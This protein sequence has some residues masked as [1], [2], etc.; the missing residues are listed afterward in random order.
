LLEGRAED[1]RSSLEQDKIRGSRGGKA[2]IRKART[3][4]VKA[5]QAIINRFSLEYKLLPRS[6]NDLCENLR[7][8]FVHE[9]EG[10]ITG[11]CSLHIVRE[12]LSEIRSLAVHEEAKGRGIGR[13][14]VLSALEEAREFGVKR[15]F[16]LTYMPEYFWQFGFKNTEKAELPHKIW[17]DCMK[18][19]RFPECDEE[20]VILHME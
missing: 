13:A 14:L 11:T 3:A 10:N 6:L 19:H 5:V 16:A 18:C 12:D 4:D 7:D 17:G 2:V 15:V 20:T 8:V 9:E 1:Y